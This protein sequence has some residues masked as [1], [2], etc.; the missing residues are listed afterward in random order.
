MGPQRC[1][2][3]GV[4]PISAISET[5]AM[6]QLRHMSSSGVVVKDT[7]SACWG[8]DSPPWDRRACNIYFNYIMC[9]NINII[10]IYI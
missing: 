10:Y 2:E 6:V 9:F 1:H 4:S 7:W 3:I 5:C 8:T